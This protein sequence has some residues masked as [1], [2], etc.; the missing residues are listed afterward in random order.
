MLALNAAIEAA[1]AAEQG[2]GFAV[3]ADEVRKLAERSS[4]AA[5]EIVALISE[6]QKG[7]NEAVRAMQV[8]AHEVE[9]G[10]DLAAKSGA[11][12]DE[13]SSAVESSNRAVTRIVS[14][15]DEMQGSASGLVAA[16]EAIAAITQ[17]TNGAAEAM[18][19][20][21]Q[22][23][24]RA[25]GSIA[26]ISEENSASAEEVSAAT[27]EMSARAEQVVASADTL[28][29]MASQLE[30]L[31]GRFRIDNNG[32]SAAATPMNMGLPGTHRARRA[33]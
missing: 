7:T 19:S 17:E 23:V 12:L 11:A 32:G 10:A 3:V 14:A 16:S 1:R 15:M 31:A 22:Q 20:I 30:G 4:R 5:K 29:D 18:T 27:E 24:A 28:A 9:A 13:I 21:A 6:V 2:K 33:A 26:A 25:V 8:G